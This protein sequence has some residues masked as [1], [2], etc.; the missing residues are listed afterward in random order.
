MTN[1]CLESFHARMKLDYTD[2]V[3]QSVSAFLHTARKIIRDYS[4]NQETLDWES[5]APTKKL[6]L[7]AK[8]LTNSKYKV[9][10]GKY[11]FLKKN[12]DQQKFDI[13]LR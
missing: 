8:S 13:G 9:L 6:W 5:P 1:N 11:M 2:G 7:Q 10:G 12:R 4:F 3:K